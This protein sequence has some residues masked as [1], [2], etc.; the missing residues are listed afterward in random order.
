MIF[1][2]LEHPDNR[3]SKIRLPPLIRASSVK[4]EMPSKTKG[5]AEKL[6]E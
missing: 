6:I 5:K 3:E 4:K 1:S 2:S